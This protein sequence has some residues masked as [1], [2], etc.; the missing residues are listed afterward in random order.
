MAPAVVSAP[1]A[2]VYA[3]LFS[4]PPMSNAIMAPSSTPSRTAF[5][6]ERLFSQ[7][8][9]PDIAEAIGEP[10]T[11]NIR[12][13]ITATEISGI[14]TTGMMPAMAFGTRQRT[15]HSTRKPESSPETRPPRKPA[16]TTTEIAPPTMPG[17]SAGRSAIA[18]AM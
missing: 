12:N 14:T 2:K 6:P 1:A 18:Y 10:T 9:S 3:T 7:F 16:P 15:I 8:V 11:T 4:G 5:V 17:V 13:P